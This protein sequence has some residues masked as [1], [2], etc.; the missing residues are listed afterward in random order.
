MK[1]L[2]TALIGAMALAATAA[3]STAS[4]AAETA[5]TVVFVHGAFADGSSWNKVIPLLQAKGLKTISVQNPLTSLAD[6][7]QHTK[8]AI[9]NAEGPVVLVGHSWGGM[10]ITETGVDDKV[11][12]LVFISAFAPEKGEHIHD[13]LHEAHGVKKIAKVPGF[14]NPIVDKNGYI[15]LSEETFIKYFANDIPE[16]D[17]K[18]LAATQGPLHKDGLDQVPNAAAWK[19]KP[20]WFIIS[21]NDQMLAP[22][23]QRLM[24]NNANGKTIELATSHVPM[25]ADPNGVAKVILEAAGK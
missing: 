3:V 24:A 19:T 4:L 2:R 6:D 17:A 20:S 15:T 25:L 5:K 16:A 10:V 11:G 23:V 7:V 9:E 22:D 12:S 18:L 13:I 14:K 1:T 21:S 8:R